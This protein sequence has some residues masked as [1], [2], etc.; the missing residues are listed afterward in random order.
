ME[1]FRQF[2]VEE[3]LKCLKNPIRRWNKETFG[4]IVGSI[5]YWEAKLTKLDLVLENENLDDVD[6]A[7]R[8][9]LMGQPDKWY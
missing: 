2:S 8:K 3:K 7:T 4:H 5:F 6:E 9:S 1:N